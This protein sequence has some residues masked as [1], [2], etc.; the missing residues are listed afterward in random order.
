MEPEI[1]VE[2]SGRV[3]VVS[4]EG[5]KLSFTHISGTWGGGSEGKGCMDVRSLYSQVIEQC[6]P[7]VLKL[8]FTVTLP[9]VLEGWFSFVTDEDLRRRNVLLALKLLLCESSTSL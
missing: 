2:A 1:V 6:Q 5:L 8:V 9:H 7:V 4:G 3:Q